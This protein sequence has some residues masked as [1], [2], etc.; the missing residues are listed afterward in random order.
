MKIS[1]LTNKEYLRL[2]GTLSFERMEELVLKEDEFS[3][4]K[5][6]ADNAESVISDIMNIA[7]EYMNDW[8]PGLS[9]VH[10]QLCNLKKALHGINKE[11]VNT[12]IEDLE[13][14]QSSMTNAFEYMVHESEL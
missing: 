2:N 7:A 12:I 14:F 9:A 1:N 6:Q 11:L 5:S 4:T 10:S 3:E 8:N 13:E